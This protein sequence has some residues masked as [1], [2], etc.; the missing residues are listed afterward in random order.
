MKEEDEIHVNNIVSCINE[1]QGYTEGM[2]YEDFSNEEEVRMS[3]VSNLQEIGEAASL[4]SDE[5]VNQFTDV[6]YRVLE[7]LKRAKFN[8]Y[9]EMDYRPVWGIIENDLPTFRDLLSTASEQ[10]NTEEDGI[11]SN[12]FDEDDYNKKGYRKGSRYEDESDDF[13]LSDEA[14]TDDTDLD[15]ED[16]R[17]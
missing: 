8:E 5:F 13:D 9:V 10:M 1:I 6:D 2:T 4:L 11:F 17:F 12:D 16:D 15:E 3:V 7:S 14:D